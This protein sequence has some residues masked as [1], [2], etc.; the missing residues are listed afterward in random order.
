MS[1]PKKILTPEEQRK[2]DNRLRVRAIILRLLAHINPRD[3]SWIIE[4]SVVKSWIKK[5]GFEFVEQ[6][7][8]PDFLSKTESLRPLTGDWGISYLEKKFNLWK[9]NQQGINKVL[10]LN[11]EKI[12]EDYKKIDKKPNSL[13]DFLKG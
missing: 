9:Y 1:R 8:L 11:S 12:G 6:F 5:Y 3:I 7:T 4:T 10:A 13:V 2:K